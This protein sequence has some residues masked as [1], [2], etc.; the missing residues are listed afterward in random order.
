M[1]LDFT[2]RI[3][4]PQGKDY[5]ADLLQNIELRQGRK[6]AVKLHNEMGI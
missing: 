4:L 3:E 2:T 6:S 5:N 1:T